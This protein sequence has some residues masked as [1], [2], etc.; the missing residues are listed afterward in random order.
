M[1][2]KLATVMSVNSCIQP[3]STINLLQIKNKNYIYNRMVLFKKNQFWF[4]EKV[5]FPIFCHLN[6]NLPNL[7]CFVSPVP[8]YSVWSPCLT[9]YFG[10]PFRHHG[11]HLNFDKFQPV[12]HRCRQ[13]IDY[14]VTKMIYM[15]LW[16]WQKRVHASRWK[17]KLFVRKQCDLVGH[18]PILLSHV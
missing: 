17:W 10:S 1:D 5:G 14:L 6:S 9:D 8:W 2:V 12:C 18:W 16:Y 7:M 3:A 13:K 15:C 11:T 4:I